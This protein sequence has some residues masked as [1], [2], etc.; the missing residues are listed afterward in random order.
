MSTPALAPSSEIYK[1]YPFRWIFPLGQ[2][3]LCLFLLAI[4]RTTRGLVPSTYVL[5]T[6][7]AVSAFNLPGGMIQLLIDV[8]RLDKQNPT[9]PGMD[10][11]FWRAATWPVINMVFWWIAGR[12]TE[13][14]VSI[15]YR[16]L[17]PRISWAEA[18]IGFLFIA[19]GVFLLLGML[20]G[21]TAEERADGALLRAGAGGGLWAFLGALS[22]I[23]RF[24][25]WRLRKKMTTQ[26][27]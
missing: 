3:V 24:R 5:P 12:A 17:K 11:F 2:L 22:V 15:P 14:L 7:Q 8:A 16:Q 19:G 4:I 10:V 20:F 18:I 23:A 9:P 25:Q 13:A 27:A 6:L 26:V 21:T 1:P